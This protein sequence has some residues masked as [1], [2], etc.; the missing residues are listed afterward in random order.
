MD[1]RQ[2]SI[3]ICVMDKEGENASVCYHFYTGSAKTLLA[4]SDML[5]MSL[6]INRAARLLVDPS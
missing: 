6:S 4:S 1:L 3:L 2:K 5:K